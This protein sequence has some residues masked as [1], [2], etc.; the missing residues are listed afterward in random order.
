MQRVMRALE[1]QLERDQRSLRSVDSD[2]A[3]VLSLLA[4]SAPPGAFPRA[5]QQRRLLQ[6]VAVA[7]RPRKESHPY[8]GRPR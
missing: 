3:R 8:N 1:E 4:L 5:G 2:V 7:G 6:S